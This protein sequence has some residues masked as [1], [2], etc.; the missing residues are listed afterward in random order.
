MSKYPEHEKMH[1]VQEESRAIG[2]FLEALPQLGL[3][4]ADV[5][6]DG[7]G[8]LLPTHRSIQD[9]IAQHLGIDLKVIEQEKQQMLE[10]IRR[11]NAEDR[12]LGR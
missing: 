1:K 6:I 11:N 10:T 5:D 8:R 4:L 12:E 2:E 9:I 7:F 3:T